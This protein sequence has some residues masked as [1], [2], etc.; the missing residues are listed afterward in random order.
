MVKHFKVKCSKATITAHQPGQHMWPTVH[1]R[2]QNS[3]SARLPLTKFYKEKLEKVATCL[4]TDVLSE[5]QKCPELELN[6]C[7]PADCMGQQ[8]YELSYL[9][10]LH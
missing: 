1:V 10:N 4:S 3:V 9:A 2:I 7:L 6:T 8:L 5:T